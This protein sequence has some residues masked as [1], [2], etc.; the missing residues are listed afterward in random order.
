MNFL[1]RW[2]L[3][4]Q[5]NTACIHPCVIIFFAN[6]DGNQPGYRFEY[7]SG[8]TYMKEF[9][10][11][12]INQDK[13]VYLVTDHIVNPYR[14]CG[15]IERCYHP[16]FESLQAAVNYQE[17]CEV[18]F[19]RLGGKPELGGFKISVVDKDKI[20]EDSWYQENMLAQK[21][22]KKLGVTE[23]GYRTQNA[24][25]VVNLLQKK[26]YDNADNIEK[27]NIDHFIYEK[28]RDFIPEDERLKCDKVFWK[29]SFFANTKEL[30]D[31]AIISC[32]A[33]AGSQEDYNAIRKA[34]GEYET[35][36]MQMTE[37]IA[38]EHKGHGYTVITKSGDI[39]WYEKMPDELI[40]SFDSTYQHNF[41]WEL[42]CFK[43]F[44]Y[45]C[46]FAD[47][48]PEPVVTN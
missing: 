1:L 31:R 43:E 42:D 15:L 16:F 4:A 29:R 5:S 3:T 6:E 34:L 45:Q 32:F 23:G 28:I 13:V 20:T 9:T 11:T 27:F 14:G 12:E 47:K 36:I 40:D 48:L 33:N 19:K 39:A 37:D 25:Q 35:R 38:K 30:V 8:Y 21:Y 10:I 17:T 2:L 18:R 41:G 22:M 24:Y 7:A 26:Y 46:R 44:K